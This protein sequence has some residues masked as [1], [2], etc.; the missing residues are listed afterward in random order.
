MTLIDC[1]FGRHGDAV[2]AIFN[3]AILNTTALYEYQPRTAAF[4]EGWFQAKRDGGL[5]VIGMLDDASGRLMGF[6]SYG[7]F[8]PHAAYRYSVEHSVYVDRDFRQRG[9]ARRLM[10]AL[11]ERAEAQQY[12]TLIGGID[13]SNAASIALHQQLDFSHAGTV[14]QAA[15][16][17]DRWLDLAFYQRILSTPGNPCGG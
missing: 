6:A 5:P 7:P 2:L 15:Y 4:V 11:I 9:V 8:R 12:H 13:A 1:E 3:D 17:F 14:R 10:T 16:K